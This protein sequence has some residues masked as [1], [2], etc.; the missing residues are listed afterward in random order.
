MQRETLFWK[1]EGKVCRLTLNRPEVLNALS[2]QLVTDLGAASAAIAQEEEVRTV[3]I[4]GAGRAFC[5]GIDLKAL[6]A[7]SIPFKFYEDFEVALRTFETMEKVV[8]AAITS[9]CIGGGLQ[10]ALA[11]DVRV[12]RDDARFGLTAVKECLLPGLGTYRL[13]RFVGLGR[14]KRL[15]LSGELIGADEA[16]A[17]GM[18]DWVVPASAFEA[19]VEEV[20][21]SFLRTASKAARLA[22]GLMADAF[23]TEFKAFLTRYLEDQR[24]ALESPDHKEAMLA[25]R[26]KRDPRF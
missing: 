1:T 5:S 7:D 4:T 25:Y 22:K 15:V 11:C 14:A 12:A 6:S 17:M 18:V 9:Y 8:V 16:L 26:E 19:K 2:Y 23:D 21:Q 20:V 13:P 3:V 10:L 24:R